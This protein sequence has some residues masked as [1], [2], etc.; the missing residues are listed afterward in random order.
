MRTFT[1][2]LLVGLAMLTMGATASAE[3]TTVSASVGPV[4]VTNVPVQ[5]C[6]DGDCQTT[7]ALSAVTLR[8]DATADATDVPTITP[9]TC[10]SGQG[11]ALV[12]QS[13][14]DDAVVSGEVT[15]T[16]PDGSSFSL[17]I[18][19]VTVGEGTTTVSACTTATGS[20]PDPVSGGGGGGGLGGL[21]GL[22]GLVLDLV[23]GLLGSLGGLGGGLF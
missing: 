15:G 22:I 1:A 9:A 18:D 14:S 13:G 21:G 12:V 23:T 16:T 11:A 3:P 8:V 7:P 10:P 17:P 4:P 6:V 5:V 20:L 19:P 2:S